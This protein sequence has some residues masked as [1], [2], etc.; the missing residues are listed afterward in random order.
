ME[1]KPIETIVNKKGNI[2]GEIFVDTSPED[3][4]GNDHVGTMVCFHKRYKLGDNTELLEREFTGWAN[5]E[6]YLTKQ[7]KAVIVLPLFLY[8]H[9]GISIKV[10]SF[11]GIGPHAAWDSGQVGFIYATK[12]SILKMW[13]KQ[14]LTKKLLEDVR[15]GLLAEVEEYDHYLTGDVYG[16]TV[17]ELLPACKECGHV[18]E[19][20]IE[21]CWGFYGLETVRETVKDI[22][23]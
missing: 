10:G 8:D 6:E 3:P 1:E 11:N 23:K 22:V 18:T 13:D 17:T 2:R 12:D 7:L 9:S 16:F 4:R 5:L 19:K 15:R 20:V 14:K 21:S